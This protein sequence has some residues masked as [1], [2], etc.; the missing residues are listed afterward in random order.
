MDDNRCCACGCFLGTIDTST[1][2]GENWEY[3][4]NNKKC[5]SKKDNNNFPYKDGIVEPK[6]RFG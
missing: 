5:P 3:V 1:E 4:C 6:A 2:S